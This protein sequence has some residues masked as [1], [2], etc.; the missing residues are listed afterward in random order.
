MKPMGLVLLAVLAAG[1]LALRLRRRYPGGWHY[2]LSPRYA[3][4]RRD[5]DTARSELNKIHRTVERELAAARSGVEDAERAR[6]DRISRARTHLNW[7]REPGRG[8]QRSSVGGVLRLYEHVLVVEADGADLDYP[9][10]EVSVI[11]EYSGKT[12]HVYISLPGGRRQMVSVP[13]DEETPETELRRFVVAVFNAVA[14][15]KVARVERQELVPQAE[16][17]LSEALADT[18]GREQAAER[19]AAVK[20]RQK[21]DK[22]IP[23]ARRELD[24]AFDRWEQLTGHRPQ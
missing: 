7:L 22:R 6:A 14:E 19:L 23:R 24:A 20:A 15:E 16:A 12:G 5:L 8:R 2:A 17:E 13:I 9:L 18:A 10:H 1:I 21:S 3:A 11:D 4:Q